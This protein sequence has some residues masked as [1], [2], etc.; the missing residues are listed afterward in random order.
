MR[1]WDYMFAEFYLYRGWTLHRL[2]GFGKKDWGKFNLIENFIPTIDTC[3]IDFIKKVGEQGWEA[4][5]MTEEGDILGF[6]FK[7]ELENK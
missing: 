1:K 5:N 3:C 2:N 7:R 4:V 6:L